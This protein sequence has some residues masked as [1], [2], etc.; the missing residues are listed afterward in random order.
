MEL[1]QGK[2][3]EVLDKNHNNMYDGIVT[4]IPFKGAIKG[5]LHEEQFNFDEYFLLV[6][7]V[8]KEKGFII[9]FVNVRCFID[10]Y[11]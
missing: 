6:N 8:I 5:K 7:R 11:N 4:D 9:S 1:I 10:L 2:C 3:Y